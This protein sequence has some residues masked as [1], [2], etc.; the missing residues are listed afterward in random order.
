MSVIIKT[1]SVIIKIMS[2]IVFST[3]LAACSKDENGSGTTDK[4]TE[5]QDN[6]YALVKW[7]N[8]SNAYLMCKEGYLACNTQDMTKADAK[9]NDVYFHFVFDSQKRLTDIKSDLMTMHIIYSETS[10]A[11]KLYATSYGR[12]FVMEDY[13]ADKEKETKSHTSETLKNW[14]VGQIKAPIVQRAINKVLDIEMNTKDNSNVFFEKHIKR[15]TMKDVIKLAD[16]MNEYMDYRDQSALEIVNNIEEK[17]PDMGKTEYLFGAVVESDLV[18]SLASSAMSLVMS[19]IKDIQDKNKA[20][21]DDRYAQLHRPIILFG[22]ETGLANAEQ[23]S[24]S[25]NTYG[26]IMA[27]GGAEEESF[28]YGVCVSEDSLSAKSNDYHAIGS[29]VIGGDYAEITPTIPSKIN[30]SNLKTQ[31]TYFYRAYCKS[32]NDNSVIWEDNWKQFTTNGELNCNN[33]AAL[34][35]TKSYYCP[36]IA[37]F[38]CQATA[39]KPQIDNLESWGIYVYYDTDE[40]YLY[41]DNPYFLEEGNTKDC[42]LGHYQYVEAQNENNINC[43]IWLADIS[44]KNFYSIDYDKHQAKTSVEVGIW[45][46]AKGQTGRLLSKRKTQELVYDQPVSVSF[47]SYEQSGDTYNATTSVEN[48]DGTWK[49]VTI[50]GMVWYP[51]SVKA[52]VSGAFFIDDV[53][54]ATNQY[55]YNSKYPSGHLVYSDTGENHYYLPDGETFPLIRQ[56]TCPSGTYTVEGKKYSI[57]ETLENWEWYIFYSNGKSL[58]SNNAI[59][60]FHDKK[61]GLELTTNYK[62][63]R[64]YFNK[65]HGL[66]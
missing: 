30:V 25:I 58:Y 46:K 64:E 32:K 6:E 35:V 53:R 63:Q 23:T 1:T 42:V 13:E 36:S 48:E 65:N 7:K 14:F 24:C 22:L 26:E 66:E 33:D 40:D 43:N 15:Q 51:Y 11:V 47:E 18:P 41:F 27:I 49:T 3:I 38:K 37:A 29:F 10:S 62:T 56:L 21:L 45:A 39:T 20:M 57:T 16:Y 12:A 8:D 9:V 31:T 59:H 34:S 61:P 2:V 19:Y 50:T 28:E 44:R 17:Y 60:Y 4:P 52:K 54:Y 55:I 5:I